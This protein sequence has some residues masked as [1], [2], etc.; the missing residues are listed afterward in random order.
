MEG[1]ASRSPGQCLWSPGR[2]AQQIAGQLGGGPGR[3]VS[4][5]A[6][7]RGAGDGPHHIYSSENMKLDLSGSPLW[8]SFLRMERT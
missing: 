5:E 2:S 8:G 4:M 6:Q 7:G 1:G 3:V